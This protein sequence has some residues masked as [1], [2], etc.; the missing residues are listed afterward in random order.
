MAIRRSQSL[1]AGRYRTATRVMPASAFRAEAEAKAKADAEKTAK[2]VA[3]ELSVD[4]VRSVSVATKVTENLGQFKLIQD[5]FHRP[6]T[7]VVGKDGK[8]RWEGGYSALFRKV[9]PD[10][11]EVRVEAHIPDGMSADMF[12]DEVGDLV[13]EHDPLRQGEALFKLNR[14]NAFVDDD[15]KAIVDG[16]VSYVPRRSCTLV[17]FNGHPVYR[18]AAPSNGLWSEAV[19]IGTEDLGTKL[20]D[21]AIDASKKAKEDELA[22]KIAAL[23]AELAKVRGEGDEQA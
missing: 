20:T 6:M 10:G 3:A 11:T 1:I 5:A 4:S 9:L 15:G 19:R 18:I 8:K 13:V 16:Y 22:A 14:K 17:A 12:I 2:G 23:Q 21:E 7:L